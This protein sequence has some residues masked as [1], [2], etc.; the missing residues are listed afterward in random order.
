MIKESLNYVINQIENNS[1]YIYGCGAAGKRLKSYLEKKDLLS[2]FLGFVVTDNNNKSDAKCIDDKLIND[3]LFLIAVHSVNR[4]SVEKELK[5]RKIEK[6]I[7]VYDLIFE[8]ELG[9]PIT[10]ERVVVSN[11][12]KNIEDKLLLGVYLAMIDNV[13]GD[14][15]KGKKIY[16]YWTKVFSYS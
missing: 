3:A 10:T 7:Y 12:I 5:K 13:L 6:Y 15:N 14:D 2:N 8:L 11:I 16:I 1:F 9:K 4:V